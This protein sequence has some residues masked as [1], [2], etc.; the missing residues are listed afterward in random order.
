MGKVENRRMDGGKRKEVKVVHEVKMKVY[1]SDEA[2]HT[3]KSKGRGGR[4]ISTVL[5]I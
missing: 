3:E 1:S 5:K 4:W 2:R